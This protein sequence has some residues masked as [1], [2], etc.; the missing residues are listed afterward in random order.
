M[1]TSS[2]APM[3]I[4]AANYKIKGHIW[5]RSK[6]KRP[7]H[8]SEEKWGWWRGAGAWAQMDDHLMHRNIYPQCFSLF[9]INHEKAPFLIQSADTG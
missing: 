7:L 1:I 4:I 6:G 5:V 2:P 3:T 9:S 8:L